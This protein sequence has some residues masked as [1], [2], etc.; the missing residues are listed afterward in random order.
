VLGHG[1]TGS[2]TQKAVKTVKDGNFI[3][4]CKAADKFNIIKPQHIVLR[5]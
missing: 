1:P 3:S 4:A 2:I 5:R